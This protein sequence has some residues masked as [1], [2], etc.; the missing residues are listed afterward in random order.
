L[1]STKTQRRGNTKRQSWGLS[2]T[3]IYGFIKSKQE[4]LEGTCFISLVL[5]K[6]K[7]TG[8]RLQVKNFPFVQLILNGSKSAAL[9][10]NQQHTHLI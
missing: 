8:I 9:I 10:Y 2:S 5:L 7:V 6:R 1:E 3:E 4:N